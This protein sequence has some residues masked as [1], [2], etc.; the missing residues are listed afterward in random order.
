MKYEVKIPRKLKIGGFD[1]SVN[2]SPCTDKE[3]ECADLYGQV[4]ERKQIIRIGSSD[5]PQRISEC[6]MHEVFHATNGIFAGGKI[7]EAQ[8][9]ATVAGFHQVMEQL[10]IRFVR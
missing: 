3:L 9:K 5:T 4:N 10:G 1:F 7:D 6:F 8:V 2:I